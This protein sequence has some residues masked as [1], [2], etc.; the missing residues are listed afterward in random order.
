MIRFIQS[1]VNVIFVQG[2]CIFSKRDVMLIS[3]TKNKKPPAVM[4]LEKKNQCV[5]LYLQFFL[6][7]L[8]VD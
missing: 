7:C 6:S 4:R 2:V 5:E 8:P 3:L 1:K